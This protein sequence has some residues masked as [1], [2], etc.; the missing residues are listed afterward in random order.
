MPC[1]VYG[2]KALGNRGLSGLTFSMLCP[3]FWPPRPACAAGCALRH[4]PGSS[5][6][7]GTGAGRAGRTPGSAA[8]GPR[9][10]PPHTAPDPPAGRRSGSSGRGQS[11][12]ASA[13]RGQGLYPSSSSRQLPWSQLA[14]RVRISRLARR[15]WASVMCGSSLMDQTPDGSWP[16][17]H[18]RTVPPWRCR[19][20]PLSQTTGR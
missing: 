5:G 4:S 13:D 20:C 17:F 11:R 12:S 18:R 14:H 7:W 16:A 8:G 1:A 19:S 9:P 2:Q 6:C 10:G 15:S 3:G